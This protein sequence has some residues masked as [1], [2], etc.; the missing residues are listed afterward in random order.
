TSNPKCSS[1]VL[2]DV[3]EKRGLNGNDTAK[4]G[5][6]MAK[7]RSKAKAA[8]KKA[9]APAAS[10]QEESLP[11]GSRSSRGRTKP[12]AGG[13]MQLDNIPESWRDVRAP[14]FDKPYFKKLSDFVAE[15][16]SH[17]TV[18]PPE[19]DVFNALKYTPF[20]EM[21]VLLLGQDPY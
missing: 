7:A 3:C 5:G 13:S 1:C 4:E 21:K 20:D 18:F 11:S 12:S 10:E 17:H 9:S 2:E 16:R 15:E 14:E 6:T 19:E 8:P